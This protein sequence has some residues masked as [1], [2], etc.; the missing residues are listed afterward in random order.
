MLSDSCLVRKAKQ[1]LL[2]HLG[3]ALVQFEQF[4]YYRSMTYLHQEPYEV[5]SWEPFGEKTEDIFLNER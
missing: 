5:T 1:N 3:Y 2:L 4:E